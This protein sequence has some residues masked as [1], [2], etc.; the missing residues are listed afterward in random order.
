VGAVQ[1]ILAYGNVVVAGKRAVVVGAG[2]LVGEPVAIWLAQQGAEVEVFTVESKPEDL[3]AA[4]G[5]ADIVVSGAGSP[6][7]IKQGMLKDG[8]VLI[9]A[10]TSES[11]GQIVGD[12]DPAC[13][14]KCSLFTPVPGG[15]GPVAV[16]C[17][18]ENTVTL[19]E[20]VA[21]K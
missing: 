21:G 8:V 15:I 1:K 5:T 20:R 19:A 16:A 18:F 4:L 11:S 3:V 7:L 10:G 12:A 14:A 17:L 2:F 9:D 13:A 6:H